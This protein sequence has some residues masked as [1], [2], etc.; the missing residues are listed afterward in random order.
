[1]THQIVEYDLKKLNYKV[2]NVYTLHT[3]PLN[4]QFIS[5]T[6]NNKEKLFTITILLNKVVSFLSEANYLKK[7]WFKFDVLFSNKLKIR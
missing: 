5:H 3:I 1:M 4:F 6:K 7:G 2:C